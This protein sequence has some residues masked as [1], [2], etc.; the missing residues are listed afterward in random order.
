MENVPFSALIGEFEFPMPK[1]P[2]FY[3]KD[4]KVKQR[5]GVFKIGTDGVLAGLLAESGEYHNILEVGTGTGLISLLLANRFPSA[6]IT[7]IDIQEEAVELASENFSNSPFA[8]RLKALQADYL[9]FNPE[10]P[11][12]LIISNPPYFLPNHQTPDKKRQTARQTTHLSVEALLN[13]APSLLKSTGKIAVIVPQLP[14]QALFNLEKQTLIRSY[15]TTPIIRVFAIY[16][17]ASTISETITETLTLYQEGQIRSEA[18]Q[19]LSQN[20]YI[21]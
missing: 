15:S 6:K 19:S 21:R 13:H 1:D 9:N 3:F 4:F 7:A 20:F 8:S 10:N 18:Y 12:D 11:F 17:S 16:G 2:Y 5:E 14:T